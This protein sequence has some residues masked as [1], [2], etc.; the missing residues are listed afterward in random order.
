MGAKARRQSYTNKNIK[1]RALK[2]IDL[3]IETTNLLDGEYLY[4]TGE[5]SYPRNTM[6]EIAIKNGAKITSNITLKTSM[7]VVG[8]KPGS[9]KLEKAQEKEISI[10]PDKE[11][12]KM[13]RLTGKQIIA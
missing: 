4:F 10:I 8:L 9:K 6:Q 11:F 3:K 7:L 12:M 13:L 2:E 1:A 5:S